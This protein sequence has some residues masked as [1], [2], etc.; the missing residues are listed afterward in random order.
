[1]VLLR[2]RRQAQRVTKTSPVLKTALWSSRHPWI[3]VGG[4]VLLVALCVWGGSMIGMNKATDAQLAPG[5]TG[6]AAELIADSGLV[7]PNVE[8]LLITSL[9]GGIL[10]PSSGAAAAAAVTQDVRSLSGVI[11]VGPPI[12]SVDGTALLLNVSLEDTVEDPEALL[13]AAASVQASH[14]GTQLEVVGGLTIDADI[15]EQLAG[16]FHTALLLS[17][18]ITVL[19]LLVAFGALIAAGVPVLLGAS[20]VLSAVGL[21]TV[22]SHVLPDGGTAAELI[23]LIGMAVGVDYSMFYLKRDREERQLGRSPKDAVTIAA[24]TAGRAIVTSGVAVMVAMAGLFLLGDTNFASMA[25]GSIIVVALAV[26]GS[27]TVLPA[28]LALLGDRV[29]KPRIPLLSRFTMSGRPA[30]VWP[31]ML[32]PALKYPALTL[33]VATIGMLLLA[34]PARDLNLRSS[35]AADLPQSIPSAAAYQRLAEAFPNEQSGLTVVVHGPDAGVAAT[36]DKIT[37]IVGGAPE[38]QTAS[39][40]AVVTVPVPHASDSQEARDALAH[41]RSTVVPQVAADDVEVVVGGEIAYDVDYVDQLSSKAPLV[42]GFVLLLTFLLMTVAFRSVLIG[43]ITIVANLLSA[44]AAF[45]VLVLV[46]QSQWGADLLG[47]NYTGG[48]IAWI[49]VFLFVILFGLS[50]DYHVLLISRIREGIDQGLTMRDAVREGIVSSAGV[51]TSAA[52]VM[53]GVFAIFAGLSLVEF[54]ELGVGLATAVLLD[55]IVVRILILPALMTL[56][57]RTGWWAPRTTVSTP[58]A[59]QLVPAGQR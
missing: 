28:T 50:M 37:S 33:L 13:A 40:L 17:L 16:D 2:H 49:P 54:K 38:V 4:W 56:L 57:G 27:L 35:T 55:A 31:A 7:R 15:N 43:V 20:S 3:A 42:I 26:L 59:P 14:P 1:M 53:I 34:L 58:E 18:P 24:S 11:D 25:S 41:F 44:A 32:R 21:Y 45:G 39:Q 9:D 12:A 47:F 8:S 46:F 51:I 6:R 30:R 36:V 19:I 22:A 10:D 23:L 48:V 52:A 29:D 5:E